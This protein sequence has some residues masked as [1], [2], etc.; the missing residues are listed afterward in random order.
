MRRRAYLRPVFDSDEP[1][2]HLVRAF[3]AHPHPADILALYLDRPI[4]GYSFR[5]GVE[6]LAAGRFARGQRAR[7]VPDSEIMERAKRML[8]WLDGEEADGKSPHE[9]LGVSQS[10]SDREILRR[11]RVLSKRVHPDRHGTGDQ[12][13]WSARQRAVNEAFQALSD[14]ESRALW[15]TRFEHRK[16]LLRRLWAVEGSGPR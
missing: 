4:P 15:R 6:Q 3:Y 5:G 9:I 1:L 12:G 10:A 16:Q 13:Y 11:Y 8:R 14:P 2:E 7:P